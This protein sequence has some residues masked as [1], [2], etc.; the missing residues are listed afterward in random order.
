MRKIFIK[1]P[2][3]RIIHDVSTRFKKVL[4]V[5]DNMFVII[6]LPEAEGRVIQELSSGLGGLLFEE[7]HNPPKSAIRMC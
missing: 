2:F 4:F 5:A 3:H 6:P 1:M 7:C